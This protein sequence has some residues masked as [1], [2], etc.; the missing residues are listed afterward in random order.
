VVAADSRFSAVRRL[1][2]IGARCHFGRTAIVCRMGRLD[3]GVAHECFATATPWRCC[4]WRAGN[5]PPC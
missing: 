1:A 5:R 2:G 3:A 4:R